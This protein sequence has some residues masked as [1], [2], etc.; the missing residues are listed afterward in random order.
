MKKAIRQAF[1]DAR[2]KISRRAITLYV[3]LGML[4]AT[5][6]ANLCNNRNILNANQEGHLYLLITIVI[7]SIFADG[8]V[9]KNN[10]NP[11]GGS[12]PAQP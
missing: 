3:L 8:M 7:T 12:P 11:P 10:K 5:D 6:T 4:V 1:E 9:N 2:G